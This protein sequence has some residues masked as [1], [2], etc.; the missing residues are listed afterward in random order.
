MRD[1]HHYPGWYFI[2]YKVTA[3]GNTFVHLQLK[4]QQCVKLVASG[5]S[6]FQSYI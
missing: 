4:S 6:V 5:L 1:A 2:Q 3:G